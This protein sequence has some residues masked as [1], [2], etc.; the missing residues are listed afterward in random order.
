MT[1]CAAS[2]DAVLL[3]GGSPCQQLSQAGCAAD[4]LQGS[5]SHLFWEFA[6]VDEALEAVCRQLSKPR[7]RISENV[8]P[9][10]TAVVGA[11]T[12]ALGVGATL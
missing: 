7:C 1:E 8:V 10:P 9:T 3:M 11:I 12:E 4:P 5:E 6:M 2:T